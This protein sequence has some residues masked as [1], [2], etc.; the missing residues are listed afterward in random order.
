MLIPYN[1]FMIWGTLR[2]CSNVNRIAKKWWP[3]LRKVKVRNLFFVAT[4]Q[5]VGFTS[6]YLGGTCAVLGVN[7]VQKYRET[8]EQQ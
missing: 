3:N 2:Y 8:Q 1:M 7:P 5:A 6:V 4:I